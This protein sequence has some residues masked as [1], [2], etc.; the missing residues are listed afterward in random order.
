MKEGED[1]EE[2]DDDFDFDAFNKKHGIDHDQPL[3]EETIK[4][5]DDVYIDAFN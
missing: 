1:D 5:N 3:K 4:E 2:D